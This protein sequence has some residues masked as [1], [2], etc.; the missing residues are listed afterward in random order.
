MSLTRRVGLGVILSVDPIGGTSYAAL[1]AIV[2][3]I[4]GADAKGNTYDSSLLT[5]K[6]ITKGVAQIDSG[7]V[8]FKIAYDPADTATTQ[9]LALQLSGGTPGGST[10]NVQAT[11]PHW[12]ITYPIVGAETQQTETF[13][14]WVTGFKRGIPKNNMITADITITL[15]GPPGYTGG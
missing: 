14:G 2:D 3:T 12:K 11:A 9:V 4:D 6:Y 7:T 10:T 13:F 1:G 5:E 8:T 15:S